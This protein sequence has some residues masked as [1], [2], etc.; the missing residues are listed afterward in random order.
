M[1]VRRPLLSYPD[2][3]KEFLLFTDAATGQAG[4]GK[5]GKKT[6][7]GMGA[8][9]AQVQ[10]GKLV[11]LG[12]AGR[13]LKSHE[14]NYSAYLLELAAAVY[15]LDKFHTIIDKFPTRLFTDHQ[16]LTAFSN[17]LSEVHT[18]TWRRLTDELVH[19]NVELQYHPGLLNGVADTLSRIDY[20]KA[21]GHEP[22]E[23][24]ALAAIED[25]RQFERNRNEAVAMF[26]PVWNHTAEEIARMQDED[27]LLKQVRSRHISAAPNGRWTRRCYKQRE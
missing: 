23:H 6:V 17:P 11:A 2:Y 4:P 9:L 20:S 26:V 14:E 22:E 25:Q 8:F 27:P 24:P 16:P 15:G 10:D 3:T 5:D 19:R 12:Y 7:G 1:L 21:A 18:K 13:G